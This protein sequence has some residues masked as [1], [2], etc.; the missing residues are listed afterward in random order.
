[1][2]DG[3]LTDRE[4]CTGAA[5]C[6]MFHSD[7]MLWFVFYSF[8]YYLLVSYVYMGNITDVDSFQ[9]G[10]EGNRGRGRF[11]LRGPS[12]VLHQLRHRARQ[13]GARGLR[14]VRRR[15]RPVL[16]PV[17][18]VRR[19]RT[20]RPPPRLDVPRN[21]PDSTGL[22]RTP[23]DWTGPDG[24]RTPVPS[25]L[26][27]TARRR[28][29]ARTYARTN[30]RTNERLNERKTERHERHERLK[31]NETPDK[32]RPFTQPPGWAGLGIATS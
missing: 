6:G 15:D 16:E 23:P 10:H 13:D 3:S 2:C 19:R 1:M 31:I 25:D 8:P 5:S 28:T 17:R 32:S 24:H 12:Q 14:G 9:Q 4:H 18:G 21:A 20:P 11:I 22:H 26:D 30:E 7:H 29:R 27:D